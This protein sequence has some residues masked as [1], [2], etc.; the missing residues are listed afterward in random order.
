MSEEREARISDLR[1]AIEGECDGL[2]TTYQQAAAIIDYMDSESAARQSAGAITACPHGVDDGACKQCYAD[3]TEQEAVGTLSVHRFRKI[4]SMVNYDFEYYGSLAD[5]TYRV[6]AAPTGAT[7]QEA[8]GEFVGYT[9]VGFQQFPV[10]SWNRHVPMGTKLYAAPIGDN[11]AKRIVSWLRANANAEKEPKAR[12]AL[13]EAHNAA[14]KIC[15]ACDGEGMI[16]SH[17]CPD[18]SQPAESSGS[19][20]WDYGNGLVDKKLDPSYKNSAES[21]RVELTDARSWLHDVMG[22]YDFTIPINAFNVIVE[23]LARAQAKGE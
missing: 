22:E 13:I 2:A 16:G 1:A 15:E 20:A 10:I 12:A 14:L 19:L 23:K 7:G 21:K 18:C 11:G 5:G 4:D 17:A 3:A 6:Y 8:V 9:K